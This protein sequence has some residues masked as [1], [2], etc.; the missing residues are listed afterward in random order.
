MSSS[1]IL[2]I[3]QGLCFVPS[4]GSLGILPIAE[5]KM[6]QI[7]AVKLDDIF[8]NF[9]TSRFED[10]VHHSR[11]SP[12]TFRFPLKLSIV[13]LKNSVIK[14]EDLTKSSSAIFLSDTTSLEIWKVSSGAYL[15]SHTSWD[16]VKY[17]EVSHVEG[18][19]YI[20][21]GLLAIPTVTSAWGGNVDVDVDND[22]EY[23]LRHVAQHCLWTDGIEIRYSSS[24]ICSEVWYND[25]HETI[26]SVSLHA[27][28]CREE[29]LPSCS[30]SWR[31]CIEKALQQTVE[32]QIKILHEQELQAKRRAYIFQKSLEVLDEMSI[33]KN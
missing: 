20:N 1:S 33:D 9:F 4:E 2:N 24:K 13:A 15:L 29:I 31:V 28:P 3:G 26:T 25:L 27:S 23:I 21:G 14:T 11:K 19:L 7:L 5:T 32:G 16:R 10:F 18:F 30:N 22:D 12:P 17:L 8:R 6:T